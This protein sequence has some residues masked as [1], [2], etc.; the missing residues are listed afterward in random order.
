MHP[1]TEHRLR[2]RHAAILAHP[3]HPC[4][5]QACPEEWAALL[6]T[7]CQCLQA[8]TDQG[9][10]PQLVAARVTR[11]EDGLLRWQS[12]RPNDY[13]AGLIDM[14]RAFSALRPADA[15]HTRT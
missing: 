2:Q 1:D 3:Q 7:L 5:L 4:D 8:V 6:D 12:G 13:Q 9:N 10:G 15:P 14:A 11:G